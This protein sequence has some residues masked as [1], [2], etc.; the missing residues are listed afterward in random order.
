MARIVGTTRRTE[1]ALAALRMYAEFARCMTET[2]EYYG[3]SPQPIQVDLPERDGVLDALREGRGAVI[4]TG[5]F[6]NWDIAAKTL[7]EHGRPINMVGCGQ[8]SR[9]VGARSAVCGRPKCVRLRAQNHARS[10][11]SLRRRCALLYKENGCGGCHEYCLDGFG[12]PRVSEPPYRVDRK[13]EL[14]G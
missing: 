11:P 9:T 2:M 3:P 5:H 1:A 10:T 8:R 6:G 12:K 13:G 7:R 14:N 4:V